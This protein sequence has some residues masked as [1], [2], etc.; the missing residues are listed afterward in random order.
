MNQYY[1]KL[2]IYS[3]KYSAKELNNMLGITYDKCWV[4]GMPRSTRSDI[5]KFDRHAWFILSKLSDDN[6]LD[7]HITNIFTRLEPILN[8]ILSICGDC[9]LVFNCSIEGDDNPVLNFSKEVISMV[10]KI[11]AGLDIDILI[12]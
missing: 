8:N 1:A 11:H 2:G 6:T 5:I 7:D 3:D 4:K 10:N 12:V 9:E